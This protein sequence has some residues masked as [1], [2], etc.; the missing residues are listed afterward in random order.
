MGHRKEIRVFVSSPGDCGPER[1][2]VARVLAE[3]NRTVCVR[4]GLFFQDV[5]WEDLPPGLG[6]PQAVIDEHLGTYNALV[7]IMWIRFGTPIPGGA[8]SGTEHE[9]QQAMSS[10]KRIGEPRVMF[11]FKQDPPESLFDLD[12]EQLKQVQQFKSTL[13]SSALCQTFQGT[14]E[15][16]SKL[17]VHLHKL[18]DHF[19]AKKSNTTPRMPKLDVSPYDGFGR[20]FREV[21][22]AYRIPET[23]ALLHVVFGDISEIRQITPVI[24]VS[25]EFDF[26]QRHPRGVLGAFEKVKVN[27]Q[28]FFDE[29][30]QIWPIAQRPTSAGLGHC[31]F[32][33]LP[34]NT[35]SIPGVLFVV[36]TRNL[37]SYPRDYGRYT[38]TPIEGIDYIV[39]RAIDAAAMHGLEAIALPLVGTGFANI[40]RTID[41]PKLAMLLRRATTL[42][43]SS[44]MQ[45]ALRNHSSA[46]RRGVVVIHSN[47]PQSEEEHSIWEAVTCYVGTNE[48]ERNRLVDQL[49]TEINRLSSK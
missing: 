16:E 34:D 35:T 46:L 33:P 5:R 22:S 42:I 18:V 32:L 43:S 15:F 23:S 12:P 41:N 36:S 2:A 3:M 49:L 30:E 20:I 19:S 10:W 1:D 14:G 39:D 37:S 6:N 26:Q 7:G 40:R 24:P 21:V 25:Q 48:K 8:G 29:I 28:P 38:N 44:K 13:Q 31:K 9:V 11:Y 17:R 45:Q 27:G 4:E 47:Q